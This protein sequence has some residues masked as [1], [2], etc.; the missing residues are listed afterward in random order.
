MEYKRVRFKIRLKQLS[1]FEWILHQLIVQFCGGQVSS[2]D[3]FSGGREGPETERRRE[4]ACC[5]CSDIAEISN[6][7]ST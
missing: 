1:L 6:F 5:H 3:I 2:I 4:T 7:C